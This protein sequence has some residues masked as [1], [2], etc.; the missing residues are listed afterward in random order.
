MVPVTD[1][2]P[3]WNNVNLVNNPN[4]DGMVPVRVSKLMM[5]ESS[6]IVDTA[7]SSLGI[8]PLRLFAAAKW[9]Q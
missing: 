7:D 4:S 6:E 2:P 8:V 3:S 5:M 9:V 1:V